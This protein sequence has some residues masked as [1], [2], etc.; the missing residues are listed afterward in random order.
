MI[1]YKGYDQAALDRQYNNRLHVPDFANFFS[2]WEFQSGETAMKLPLVKDIRYGSLD[3]EK[4]DLFPSPI[5]QS[6]TLVFIH[7][8]YWHMLDKDLFHFI[9]NGF[10]AFGVTIVLLAYPL[11]PEYSIDQMLLSCRNALYWLYNNVAAYNGNPDELFVAGHSA[12]GHL[13][14]MLMATDWKRTGLT[15]PAD[16]IKGT[17]VMSGLFNLIPIF[18]SYLNTK[19]KMDLETAHRNS[20]V[21]LVPSNSCPLIIAVGA[22][23]TDEFQNQSIEFSEAWKDK[24]FPVH[25]LQLPAENHFSIVDAMVEKGSG[26][27]SAISQMMGLSL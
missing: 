8:G 16:M 3:R 20:P 5:P 27:H 25:L 4:L 12:G 9:A 22:A 7:G 13:A 17:C 2:R 1:V 11:A 19:I 14:A 15:I 23:E 18:H 21:T 24:G 10:H 26:L 6:K